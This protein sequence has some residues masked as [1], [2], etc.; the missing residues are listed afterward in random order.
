MTGSDRPVVD[1]VVVGAGLAGLY[2][3]HRFRRAGLTVRVFEAGDDIGGTWH[4]NRYPGARVDIPSVDYMYSFD[5]EWQRDWHWSEKYATQPEILRYLNHVA[6]KFDLR[7]DITF[8][9][10]VDAARWDAGLAAWRVEA[11][12]ETTTCRHLV[13]AT[14][15]LS[16][17]KD[18]DIEGIGRF[19]G[20]TYFTSHWPRD[21]VDFTGRRVAVIGT[22]SSGIQCIPHIARQARELIVFQRTPNFS[23]PAH[24]GP[25]APGKLAQMTDESGYRAAARLSFGG[26]PIERTMTPTFAVSEEERQDRYERAW[27]I[28]ELLELLNVYSDVMSDPAANHELAEFFRARIRAAVDDPEIAETLCP[29]GYPIGAKR[30]CLDTDY[31][32]TFNRDNVRLVDL[33]RDPLR[34]VTESGVDTDHESFCVDAIVFATGFDAVTG[35]VL[36]VDFVGREGRTLGQA[37]ADGPQTYLGLTVRG[38]PNLFLIT[39]PGSPSVL[40]NMAVSIEQ[41]VDLAAEIISHMRDNGFDTVEPTEAAVAG[42]M[43]HVDDCASIT[44]FPQANS[45]YRGANIP[46]KPRVFMPYTAGVDFYQAACE[47]MIARDHLGFRFTGSSGEVCRDGVVRRLQPDVQMVLEQIALLDLPPLES[48]PAQ[49]ARATFS[50]IIAMYPPGPPVADVVDGRFPGADGDL[51]YRLYRPQSPGPHPIVLYFHGG[52]WVLGDSTSDDALCRDLC[53][54]IGAI[55]VS[56]DYR[57]A[58]EHRFPAAVDDAV[59]ALA[60]V[61]DHAVD[62]GA[63]PGRLVVGGWSAGAGLATVVCHAARAAGGPAIAGQALL[64]PVTDSD[65]RRASY[66][67]NGSGYDLDASLMQWFFD[68]YCDVRD[69]R[70]PRIAPLRADDLSGLPPVV[71]VTNE[72]DVL[73]DEGEAYARA[74]RSAGVPVEHIRAR[75]H[76]HGSLTMVGLVVSGAPVREQFAA[77][78][79]RF[80]AVPKAATAPVAAG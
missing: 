23:L 69:R 20:A 37:W 76:T 11:G 16:I 24:N 2:A 30:V 10:R 42:W 1:V 59:A 43:Q 75:G 66:V 56:A 22:G 33:R 54:R 70:D 26:V 45:W 29:T 57:H 68:Q 52:G 55:V 80:L 32:A 4:W 44:L 35:A 40:S 73:R 13:M 38:F 28:G 47:E 78:V 72:F 41:H 7:R 31:F 6:D 67:E 5:P 51:D 17:P 27:Q 61:V 53:G 46:G 74:L 65:T 50:A 77:A 71:M 25:L 49:D 15:C 18:P 36:S 34:S 21:P 39:G 60:W 63:D 19:A 64:A 9:V 14:G 12:S 62:M 8:D 58:P 79:R 3:V 48:M